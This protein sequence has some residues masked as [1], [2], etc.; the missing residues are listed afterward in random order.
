MCDDL[1]YPWLHLSLFFCVIS[2]NFSLLLGMMTLT[3][4]QGWLLTDLH[5]P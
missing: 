1:A 3:L 2:Y 5:L 4:T